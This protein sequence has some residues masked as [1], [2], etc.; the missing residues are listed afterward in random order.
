MPITLDVSATQIAALKLVPGARVTLRDFRD[1]AALAI[2]TGELPFLRRLV[3]SSLSL[4]FFFFS[5]LHAVSD[6]YKP[7]KHL[8]AAHVFGADDTAHPAVSYLHKE[9]QEFYIGGSVQA[10]AAPQHFDYVSLRCEYLTFLT[11]VPRRRN[12]G[13]CRS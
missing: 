7:D 3:L 12:R 2:L 4:L 10:V 8:E 9:A 1:E 13:S 5:L 6:I 11:A